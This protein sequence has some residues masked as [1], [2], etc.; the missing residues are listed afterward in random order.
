[1]IVA[2]LDSR[3]KV[4]VGN[5]PTT[6]EYAISATSNVLLKEFLAFIKPFD[7]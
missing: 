6:P 2:R 1:L 5:V 4:S 3:L 7:V